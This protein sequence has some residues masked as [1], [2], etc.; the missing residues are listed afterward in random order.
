[1]IHITRIL[2]PVDFSECSRHAL[3]EAV[4]LAHLY[5]ACVTAVHVFPEAIAADPFA[6]LPEFQPLRLT[7][8]HRAH[9]LEHLKTFATSEGAEPRRINFAIREGAEIDAEILAAAEQITPDVI[10]MGTHGRSGF[11]RVMLGSVAEKV[12][13]KAPCPV[14]T[15]SPKAPDAVPAGP[16]PFTRILCGIDFSDCSLAA[17]EYAESLA[18]Q[19]GAQLDVLSVVQLIPMYDMTGAVPLY[20][21]GLLDDLKADIT[22]QLD[23]VVATTTSHIAVERFV[24]AGTPHREIV[25]VATERKAELVVLGAYSHG[26]VDHLFFGSTTNHV[27][28]QAR[29]PVLTVR[30]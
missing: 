23:R 20:Y 15:V 19:S 27:V 30:R 2:C 7:D 22:R 18:S 8:R 16:A 5:D 25:R 9:L 11:Q 12:L 13:R 17:L 1:M 21:P 4:A 28:R 24:T 10:V 26:A 29:C 14:L 6:G 3:D